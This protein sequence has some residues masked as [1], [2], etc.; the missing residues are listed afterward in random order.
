MLEDLV[1]SAAVQGRLWGARAE[2]WA[3]CV[4][5]VSLPLFGAASTPPA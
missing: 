1:G 2:D 5:Q 3:S 4:E